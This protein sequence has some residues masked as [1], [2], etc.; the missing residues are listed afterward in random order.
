[1]KTDASQGHNT[2]P[3]QRESALALIR[4]QKTM[5]LATN[6]D[7]QPWAAPVYY[8]Y[9]AQNFYFFSSPSSLHSRHIRT[10]NTAAATIHADGDRLEQLEGIQMSGRVQL[11]NKP[12]KK[13]SVTA[14][15]LIKFPMA[16]PLLSGMK[17]ATTDL[18]TKVDLYAFIP[19]RL[20]YMNHQMGFGSR[21]AVDLTPSIQNGD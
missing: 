20:Y 6:M 11:I 3:N 4:R 13:L 8:V 9:F 10:R 5:V 21:T 15:Y 16:R 19:D 18:R 17:T 12:L 14:R 7:N 2:T 1:M